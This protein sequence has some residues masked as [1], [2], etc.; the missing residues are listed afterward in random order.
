MLIAHKGRNTNNEV[1][2]VMELLQLQ[3]FRELARNGHLSRT[4]EALHIAQP[5]LSQTIKRLESEVGVPLFD[6]VC[7]RIVLNDSGRTFL[8]YTDQIF[9][10][11]DRAALEL[12]KIQGREEKT[13]ILYI[14]SASMFLPEIVRLIQ[15]ADP[16]I[17]LRI[18]CKSPADRS[19]F[20]ALCV[21]SSPVRPAQSR[22]SSL[23]LRERIKA[24]L[25]TEHPL[26][27]KR[28]LTW[29]DLEQE[30]F[31]SLDGESDLTQALHHFFR[32]KGIEP[33]NTICAD[34]PSVMRDL[35]RLNLGIAFIPEYTWHGFAP[36]TVVLRTVRDLPME[37]FLLLSWEKQVYQTHAWKT[38]KN[39]ITEY[40]LNLQK[41]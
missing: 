20:P 2:C 21:T 12:E 31:I 26:A 3:Y 23:L 9:D 27:A 16:E 33:N 1:T 6:R 39:I 8:K 22:C 5:S 40:F 28:E 36:D 17:R 10:A 30:P 35:L 19:G 13:V 34:T 38:C 25:P 24:A 37:R 15:Q 41:T 14:C 11:L 18:F 7:N 32:M 29:K 4:A